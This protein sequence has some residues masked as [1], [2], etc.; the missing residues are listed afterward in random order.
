VIEQIPPATGA[1]WSFRA[2]IQPSYRLRYLTIVNKISFDLDFES[3]KAMVDREKFPT[4]QKFSAPHEID[5]ILELLPSQVTLNVPDHILSLWFPPGPANGIMEGTAL[6]RAQSYAQS[7]GCRFA[8]H[9][10]TR[11]GIFYRQSEV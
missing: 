8:Y 9:R 6:E 10:A 4:T 5:E 11:E 1:R 7:G 2:V 3:K